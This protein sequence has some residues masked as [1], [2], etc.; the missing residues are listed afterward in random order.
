[1]VAAGTDFHISLTA[2]LN[3][4]SLLHPLSFFPLP[5]SSLSL[6]FSFLLFNFPFLS[7]FAVAVVQDLLFP[8]D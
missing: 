3:I 4:P 5:S 7:S 8:W 1:M 2:L 6:L